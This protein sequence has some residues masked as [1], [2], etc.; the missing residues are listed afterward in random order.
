MLQFRHFLNAPYPVNT[1]YQRVWGNALGISLFVALFLVLFQPF[2]LATLEGN[3]RLLL[4]ASYGIPCFPVIT[5]A[6]FVAVWIFRRFDWEKFWKV[7]HE[8][9]LTL[10]IPF[11]IGAANYLYSCLIFDELFSW[12]GLLRMEFYTIAVS[13]FPIIGVVA[14][15]WA[16]LVKKHEALARFLNQNV[17]GVLS[18]E[19]A[20]FVA[21]NNYS[22]QSEIVLTGDNQGE[23][24]QLKMEE[25]VYIKAEGNYVEVVT[26]KDEIKTKSF[27]L[28]TTLK[29]VE[30]QLQNWNHEIL[31]C[32]RS[33][34]VNNHKISK[35]T[36]NAQGLS[37]SMGKGRQ[38]I[39][40]SRK[41][42]EIFRRAG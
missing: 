23:K 41:Y 13:F 26:E 19:K 29:S 40:V 35:A 9:I 27:L 25:L 1:S 4:I 32:H 37:L 15:D 39:P 24:L 42:V 11:I 2:G 28:R 5:G 16:S 7:K 21:E 20:T 8:I 17:T 31:R 6:G 3:Y 14:M 33:F 22:S 38:E 34:L 36:G 12:S 10:V 18:K 30:S